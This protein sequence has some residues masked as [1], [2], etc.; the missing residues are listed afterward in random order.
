[1]IGTFANCTSLK[2]A[3]TIPASVTLMIQTFAGC[4]N[5]T[6]I[7][8]INS[9]KVSDAT[10]I[11]YGT[12]KSITLAVPSSSTTYTTMNALTTS[13]GKPSNVRLTTY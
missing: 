8:R 9:S 3:P 11:F 1:M 13:N 5:L 4:T 12:S 6:G 2:T 7:V 10:D